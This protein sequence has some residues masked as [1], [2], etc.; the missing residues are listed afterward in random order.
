MAYCHRV[1]MRRSA[2]DGKVWFL[3]FNLL[4][5]ESQQSM[6][7]ITLDKFW[8]F[9]I[10]L[11]IWTI[12]HQSM[13]LPN[14]SLAFNSVENC[15]GNKTAV[16]DASQRLNCSYGVFVSKNEYH[17]VPI[18]DFSHLVE[19]CLDQSGLI[20]SGVCMVL[21]GNG[22]KSR[23]CSEFIKGCPNVSYPSE[24]MYKFPACTRI[25]RYHKCYLE[26]AN[27]QMSTRQPV[28]NIQDGNSTFD[29]DSTTSQD[30]FLQVFLPLLVLALLAAIVFSI[31]LI[32][33]RK[34]NPTQV[35]SEEEGIHLLPT[36]EHSGNLDKPGTTKTLGDDFKEKVKDDEFQKRFK[37]HIQEGYEEV[38]P[39][40]Q[41]II[42]GE[43]GV[44]KTTLLYRLQGRTE[45]EIEKITST[46]GVEFHVRK[47][48]FIVNAGNL[49]INQEGISGLTIDPDTLINELLSEKPES[50]QES[51][52]KQAKNEQSEEKKQES[53]TDKSVKETVPGG[54][55]KD[56]S[57]ELTEPDE[58]MKH[59]SI[60]L[61]EP[62]EE[63]KEMKTEVTEQA[64]PVTEVKYTAKM[65]N[66][67]RFS[68]DKVEKDI[69]PFIH[70]KLKEDESILAQL[71][72]KNNIV[73]DVLDFAGQG[74]YYASHQTFIREDAIYIIVI[75]ASRSV[76]EKCGENKE[77][78]VA[79]NESLDL[80]N[81]S[82]SN[83]CQKDYVK[84]WLNTIKIHGGGCEKI[85]FVGTH[86]R[87]DTACLKTY[88]YNLS[89]N[90]SRFEFFFLKVF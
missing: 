24:E 16:Q 74:A 15:P 73:L 82:F 13:V 68:E 59:E 52:A 90:S 23:P 64:T 26:D 69:L 48:S 27:C 75:D 9:G 84:Y 72:N 63:M 28:T 20:Q 39:I 17:C 51:H 83:W 3:F 81:T 54:E 77:I 32:C 5:I 70:R 66:L 30:I 71:G 4:R 60:E 76:E 85:I 2:T 12:E 80:S 21:D 41:I 87:N 45:E 57:I 47:D 56:E 7:S 61:T 43:N 42:V 11:S 22:L 53:P 79:K 55:K 89:A 29:M 58:E 36:N 10:L 37:R 1:A 14:S 33:N 31:Y 6:T 40:S 65:K 78:E 67:A 44:G 38:C 8:M 86:R 88:A 49:E 25:N 35:G 18:W 34:G 19:F 46:R 62:D 50:K